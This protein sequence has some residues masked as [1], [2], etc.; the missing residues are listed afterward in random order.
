MI[1]TPEEADN[2]L[3]TKVYPV[4]DLV[5][6][7]GASEGCGSRLRFAD[8]LDHARR[9]SRPLG[10]TWAGRVRSRRSRTDLSIV[11]SQTQ[12]VHEEI[13]EMLAKL[14]K[15]NREQGGKGLPMPRKAKPEAENGNGGTSG[16]MGGGMGG[17]GQAGMCG[18]IGDARTAGQPQSPTTPRRPRRETPTCCR[19]CAEPTR[20]TRANSPA[21]SRRCTTKR[22]AA[23]TPAMRSDLVSP[24]ARRGAGGEGLAGYARASVE[25]NNNSRE[26]TA[27]GM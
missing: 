25:Q 14:R 24:L 21:N 13:E 5:L 23:S 1:T 11:V 17:M 7:E 6:P 22:R 4:G 3:E 2:Q 16:G 27:R 26:P 10:T 18:G 8:R 12:D 15:I 19:A 9:S 20:A